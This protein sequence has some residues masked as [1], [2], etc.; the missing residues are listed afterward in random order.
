MGYIAYKINK[1]IADMKNQSERNETNQRCQI[2]KKTKLEEN[3]T[4]LSH[5]Q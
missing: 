1:K 4:H 2:G 3:K 5:S